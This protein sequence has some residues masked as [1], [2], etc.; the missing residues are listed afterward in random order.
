[1]RLD[2]LFT[3]WFDLM[4]TGSVKV[5]GTGLVRFLE[6]EIEIG[7]NCYALSGHQVGEMGMGRFG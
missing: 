6:F 1:V 2:F 4:E 7:P 3:F 5:N